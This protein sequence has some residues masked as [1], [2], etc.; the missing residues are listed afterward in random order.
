MSVADDSAEERSDSGALPHSLRVESRAIYAAL[1]AGVVGAVAGLIL[2]FAVRPLPL[3]G[4][5]AFGSLV[6]IAAGAIAGAS[7]AVGYWRVRRMPGQEWRQRL[8]AATFTVNTVA[9]GLVHVVLAALGALL[10]FFVLGLGFIGLV[11]DPFWATVLMAVSLGLSAYLAYLSVSRMTTQ[12]MSSL[13]MSF[14]A[15]GTVTAMVTAPDPRWWE[16]HFSHLGTFW[17]ISGLMFNGTLVVGGL[18]VTAFAVYLANDMRVLS[19]RRTLSREQAPRVIS[20]MFIIMGVMLAG[21]GMVP[22]NV[23]LLIHNLCASGMAIMFI[24]MLAAGPW[25]LRGMP[26]AYFLASWVFLAAVLLSTALFLRGFFGLT[27][28]EIVVFALIFG[29]ISVF[30]RFLGVAGQREA[31]N[32]NVESGPRRRATRVRTD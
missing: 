23:S 5:W 13:L 19:R 16:T 30:I 3:S 15:I 28:F 6:A 1:A 29:W 20:T 7:S 4:E 14:V 27:A 25:I 21:V 31:I 8:S 12:R 2:G 32:V 17:S 11:V 26:R 10:M 22:V 18:L 24:G 9:V